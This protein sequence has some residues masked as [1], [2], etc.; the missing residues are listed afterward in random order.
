[1]EKT[2]MIIGATGMTG[3]TLT[4]LIK[5]NNP[6]DQVVILARRAIENLPETGQFVQH[7]VDFNRI[8]EYRDMIR[9]TTLV[10][11][12]GTTAKKAGSKEKFI[13]VDYEYPAR[14]A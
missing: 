3:S 11:A 1:M 5:K 10:S 2:L 9:A 14:T 7:I 12:L 6:Y 4:N 8:E 13:T